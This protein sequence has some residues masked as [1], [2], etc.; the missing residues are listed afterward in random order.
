MTPE[1]WQRVE[2][3]L[4]GALDRPPQKRASFLHD[5]CADD[6][7]LKAE[8]LSLISAHEKAGDFIEQPAIVQ[9]AGVFA[10][11]QLQSNIGREIGPYRIVECLGAGGMGE[12]YLA[13]DG[14]LNRLVALKLL[15]TYL[16]ADNER[17]GR[18]QREARAASALNHPNIL[19]I[20]EVGEAEGVRFI[21][22]EYIDGETIRELIA[23]ADLTLAEILDIATQLAFALSAA[24]A[25]GIV[26]RDI[27]PENIMRRPDGLVK[28]LDFGIAKLIEQ[29]SSAY[30]GLAGVPAQTETGAVVGTVG[31]MSPEQARGL[32]VDERSDLW[33]LGVV[34]YQ[35]LTHREP[36]NGETRLDTM[37]NILER[38]AVPLFPSD[39][40][41]HPELQD[42]KRILEK[43]LTKERNQRYQTANEMLAEL[44][45][46]RQ[47][48]ESAELCGQTFADLLRTQTVV[49]LRAVA[50]RSRFPHRD[51]R[52]ANSGRYHGLTR[53]ALLTLALVAL[54]IAGTTGVF[55]FRRSSVRQQL[56]AASGSPNIVSAGKL[57][58]EMSSAEQLG[59]I[60]LQE[61]R[62]SALMGDRPVK[63]N[64]EA[65]RSIKAYLDLYAARLGS[66]S[67]APGKEDLRTLYSRPQPYLPLIARSFSARKVPFIIGI[68]LPMI[69]SE[70]RPC[71]ENEIGAKGLFQ[72]LPQTAKQYGVAHEDMCD[73]EQMAPA[74]A[75]YIADHMAELGD[76]SESMTL[77]LLSYNRGAVW[78]R[79]TLRHLRDADHYERNFWTLFANREKLDQSFR[80][81]SAGYVPRF[82]AAAII[83]ENPANFQLQTEPLSTLTKAP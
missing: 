68:Y 23:R 35:M 54:L 83:G 43:A 61:Q 33:S 70:Y 22:T 77:V 48:L 81:E 38:G 10:T 80:N 69:E 67:N 37:V 62:I 13:Q 19:T 36:F 20:H 50:S 8:T 45:D 55:L 17:L 4:Q 11:A 65:L 60:D 56:N 47:R 30:V 34:L 27:K 74:A 58:A 24:H 63:L 9:D 71:F 21:A 72:F 79:S 1:R 39:Y 18:F 14:R 15:P 57:Y 64:E 28:I 76:D 66:K 51:P 46:L 41:V 42:L 44:Q 75:H 73:V 78:V 25:A 29:P 31:Y 26:H 12:V 82:F 49:H 3:I 16:A 7:D 2:E 52:S 53:K 40:G 6:E 32:P 5:A 59:F